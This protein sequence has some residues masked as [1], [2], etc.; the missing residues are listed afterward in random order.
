[1]DKLIKLKNLFSRKL[2]KKIGTHYGANGQQQ[3]VNRLKWFFAYKEDSN[4][5]YIKLIKVAVISALKK[6]NLEPWCIYDG[7]P[8]DTTNWLEKRGVK[9]IYHRSTLYAEI[10]AKFGDDLPARGGLGALLRI[11]IPN[12]ILEKEI[13]DKYVLYTDCDVIFVSDIDRLFFIRPKYFACAP[14]FD[15]N[16]WSNI[17]TGVMIMNIKNLHK[18]Y[19][20]FLSFVRTNINKNW[21]W[22]QTGYNLFYKGKITKLPIEYNWKP[23][24]GDSPSKKIVHFHGPKPI[25]REYELLKGTELDVLLNIYNRDRE[26][27]QKMFKEWDEILSSVE[28]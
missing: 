24:W 10:I 3:I 26:T 17:N 13:N 12:I 14:E 27:Y 16:D 1:M 23:Y 4:P 18:T 22:D 28:V 11:D 6:T 20:E 5:D 25:L 7:T 15:P 21:A 8:S 19:D 9:I 2:A